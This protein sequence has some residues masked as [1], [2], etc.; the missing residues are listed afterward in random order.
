MVAIAGRL[1]PACKRKTTTDAAIC[2]FEAGYFPLQ[3][4]YFEQ[5][6]GAFLRV[7]WFREYKGRM[8]PVNPPPYFHPK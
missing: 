1:S 6:G 4:E 7:G 8:W 5:G 2:D 3:V